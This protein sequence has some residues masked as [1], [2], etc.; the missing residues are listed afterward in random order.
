MLNNRVVGIIK[1]KKLSNWNLKD[2]DF[3]IWYLSISRL[4]EK[5]VVHNL[6]KSLQDRFERVSDI[7]IGVWRFRR[8]GKP[9]G[10]CTTYCVNGNYYDTYPSKTIE[11]ALDKVYKNS[12]R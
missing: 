5:K 3:K 9:E 7:L 6:F 11:K 10:W 4:G 12:R 1:D 2:K 8:R